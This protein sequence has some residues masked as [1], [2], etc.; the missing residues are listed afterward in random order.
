MKIREAKLK[1]IPKIEEIFV[2]G[3][4]DEGKLQHSGKRFK[5]FIDYFKK[6]KRK[7]IEEFKKDIKNN[8]TYVIVVEEKEEIIGFGIT[9]IDKEDKKY[10]ETPMIYV[11]KE[12]RRK[13]IGSKIKRELLRWLKNKKVKYASTKIFITNKPSIKLNEKFGYKVIAVKMEKNLI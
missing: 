10:G 8:Q 1:D 3:I 4:A 5:D 6:L 9:I 13:G 7:R 2:E 11:K 12:F